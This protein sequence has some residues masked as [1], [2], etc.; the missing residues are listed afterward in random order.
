MRS[1]ALLVTALLLVPGVITYQTDYRT[2]SV[3]PVI[4]TESRT[5]RAPVS[6]EVTLHCNPQH[7]G[8]FVVVWKHGPDVLTAGNMMVSPDSRYS[9]VQYSTVLQYRLQVQPLIRIQP[10][11]QQHKTRGCRELHMLHR[12]LRSPRNS[13][14]HSGDTR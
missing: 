10:E 2:V 6:D 9:T 11:D 5:H 1:S 7:L 4:T 12:N 8:K 13:D 3:T 14:S